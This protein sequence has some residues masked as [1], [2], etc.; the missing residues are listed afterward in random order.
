[1]KRVLPNTLFLIIWLLAPPVLLAQHTWE[2]VSRIV[3]VGDVHG[4]YEN[5]VQVLRDAGIINRR[6]NWVADDT[7]LVQLG[8]L[9]DRGPDTDKA[10]ELLMKLERQAQRRGG[11]VHVLIGN[12]EAMNMLGDLR[13]VHP[14]EFEA[15]INRDSERL[16]DRWF[17][18]VVQQ[19][20]SSNPEFLANEE[21]IEL[22]NQQVPLGYVEH[23]IAWSPEGEYGSWVLEHN[24]VIKINDTLFLHGGLGPQVLGMGIDEIN[25]RVLDELRLAE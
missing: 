17:E 10:I 1:M 3:A 9:P 20:R 22:F 18:L 11:K 25:Q 14:G 6:R 19:Q 13:Y 7:H 8:D 21:F 23:R 16:R 12:H 5:F 15:F 24:A 2:N 4:D